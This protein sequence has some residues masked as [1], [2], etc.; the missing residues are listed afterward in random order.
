MRS[1]TEDL[2]LAP[3]TRRCCEMCVAGDQRADERFGERHVRGVVGGDVGAKFEGPTH[4]RSDWE[5]IQRHRHECIDC[6]SEPSIGH[7][8]G[9]PAS[10]KH[11]N[12]FDIG[13]IRD[14]HVIPHEPG[15][16]MMTVLAIVTYNVGKH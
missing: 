10:P 6:S 12:R 5:P 2:D 7:V 8:T 11:G 3:E 15:A 13:E 9:E 1:K 14:R 4:E 16:G